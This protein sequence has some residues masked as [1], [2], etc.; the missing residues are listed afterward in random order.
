MID[1]T[2]MTSMGKNAEM[3]HGEENAEDEPGIICD[4]GTLDINE[5]KILDEFDKMSFNKDSIVNSLSFSDVIGAGFWF[6]ITMDTKEETVIF[7]TSPFDSVTR[8]FIMSNGFTVIHGMMPCVFMTRIWFS[9]VIK[10]KTV[11]GAQ[12]QTQRQRRQEIHVR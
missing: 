4:G 12:W 9:C 7:V 11:S 5:T 1:G 2:A 10:K 6:W 8:K 3:F